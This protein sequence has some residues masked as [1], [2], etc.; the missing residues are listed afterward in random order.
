MRTATNSPNRLDPLLVT[1]RFN[2]IDSVWVG[3][4][5]QAPE[6]QVPGFPKRDPSVKTTMSF[7]HMFLP[8]EQL[9]LLLPV[10]QLTLIL[11]NLICSNT[12][13]LICLD[14]DPPRK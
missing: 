3:I 7:A 13:V 4:N 12:P 8:S 10:E 5:M 14:I 2:L 1:G 9:P 6:P 11:E